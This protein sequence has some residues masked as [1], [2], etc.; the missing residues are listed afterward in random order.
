MK[1]PTLLN[2]INIAKRITAESASIKDW[3]LRRKSDRKLKEL[4]GELVAGKGYIIA[5]AKEL[6]TRYPDLMA[7]SNDTRR[8]VW[9]IGKI[10]IG[11]QRLGFIPI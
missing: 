3:K 10:I 7:A 11:L 4:A 5:S 9:G 1:E 8:H 6:S 2:R